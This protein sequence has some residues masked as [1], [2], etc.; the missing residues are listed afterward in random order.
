MNNKAGLDLRA[1]D[2]ARID[3]VAGPLFRG[4][5]CKPHGGG[6]EDIVA[7]IETTRN[8]TRMLRPCCMEPYNAAGR[9]LIDHWRMAI[10][11]EEGK[12]KLR[13]ND[14]SAAL[15]LRNISTTIQGR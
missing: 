3:A 7:C 10:N 2:F 8:V 4:H 15:M 11:T 1:Y 5:D 12:E 14:E 9:A 13:L 6:Y